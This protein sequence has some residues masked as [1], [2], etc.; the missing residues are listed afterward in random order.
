MNLSKRKDKKP[1]L[2]AA[3]IF[4]LYTLVSFCRLGNSYAP[5]NGWESEEKNAEIL[6][7]LGEEREIGKLIFYL[8][9][10]EN[11]SLAL[12]VGSGSP[13]VW[14][15]LADLKMSRVYQWDTT[16]I[17]KKGR[18][19][20][21]VTRNQFTDIKELIL[22]DSHGVRFEPANKAEYPALF[23]EAW[24]FPGRPTFLTGTVFDESVFARTAY[25]YLHGIRSYE[26]T[27][28]PLGKLMISIGI[29]LFGMNP[30]GW[31]F[32]GTVSGILLL[33]V[34]WKFSCR[35]FKN[36]WTSVGILALFSLDFLHFTESRLGQVDSFLVLFMTGMYYFMFRYYEVMETGGPGAC[37][38][39]EA[40]DDEAGKEPIAGE[41]TGWRYL[42]GSG[43]CMGAA[44]SCKWSGFYG[45]AGLALIW[46]LVM[47]RGLR[48]KR[49]TWQYARRTCG[50]CCL[51]FLLIPAAIYLASYLPYVV[52]DKDMGFWER[53]LR[54]QVNMYLYH[55]HVG[56]FHDYGSRWY[57]WPLI[58]RPVVLFVSRFSDM[59]ELV[60]FMGNPAFWW[61]GI[62]AF[63]LCLLRAMERKEGQ[64]WFLLTAYLAPMLPWIL[65]SRYSFLY[66][67]YPSLPFLALMIG[68]LADRGGKRGQVC[69]AA[70]VAAS[71]ILF[72]LF[73][74]VLSGQTV[75]LTYVTRW[76]QWL[77]TWKLL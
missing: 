75:K 55:S 72:V 26:D 9:K 24:M 37:T 22:S 16:Q 58:I 5:S 66:H 67:Y 50:V 47:A 60:V 28:P 43:L 35:L 57:Q 62:A 15:E 74:P 40:K 76:L 64:V 70:C 46:V 41:E 33:A 36:P 77:P 34:I 19:L 51:F 3:A 14:E 10:Y 52:L 68:F 63:F 31:R 49:I 8:G 61:T 4:I 54:N 25:E 32:A 39:R 11:R 17:G 27:H 53:V 23:D 59:T 38:D 6:L 71:G 18:Y 45:A 2:C 30:F 13:V 48:R 73:Y 56:G 69:L 20:R 65:I 42:A 21:L 29:A 44:I 1:A 7:D 12:F